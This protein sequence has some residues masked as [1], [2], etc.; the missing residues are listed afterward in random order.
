MVNKDKES[1]WT[2]YN[3]LTS[4]YTVTKSTDKLK[5]IMK[6]YVTLLA[7]ELK[8]FDEIYIEG[9][10]HGGLK[11]L[12]FINVL[13]EN[14]N[15][16]EKDENSYPFEKIESIFLH[17]TPPNFKS[18]SLTGKT[19]KAMACLFGGCCISDISAHDLLPDFINKC[20]K[21]S[22]YPS[23]TTY[24]NSNDKIIDGRVSNGFFRNELRDYSGN[25]DIQL[26]NENSFDSDNHIC[27]DSKTIFL[28]SQGIDSNNNPSSVIC[29][30]NLNR[31][32]LNF[33]KNSSN[34]NIPEYSQGNLLEGPMCERKGSN[35]K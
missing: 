1:N 25:K 27:R 4:K 21:I 31:N 35:S 13:E 5:L 7:K 16:F 29:K 34:L 22:H 12:L 23:I 2:V 26:F 20:K 10:S 8:N 3:C 33:R 24:N 11:S 17:S 9:H 14:K 6:E 30:L 28:D 19:T 15:L 18:E 32:S